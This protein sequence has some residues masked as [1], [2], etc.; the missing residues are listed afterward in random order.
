MQRHITRRRARQDRIRPV[1]LVERLEDDHFVAGIDDGHHGRH[2]RFG[3]AAAHRDLFVGDHGHA[4]ATA[5][6]ARDG[7]AQRPGAPG[8]RVL[9]DVGLN[10]G[11]GGL[12]HN[13]RRGKVGE[14]LREIDAAVHLIE[15]RHLA[16]HRLGELRG[17]LRSGEFGHG[18]E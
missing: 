11:A 4:V 14:S 1:V 12:F 15:P 3:G 9:I 7:F 2:H 8:D 13:R 17:F 6:L 5:E 16:D 18:G 10:R